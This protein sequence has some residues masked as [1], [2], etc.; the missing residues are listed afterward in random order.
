M[1]LK[2]RAIPTKVGGNENIDRL[3]LPIKLLTSQ[4]SGL[5]KT[6]NG[7]VDTQ[8]NDSLGGHQVMMFPVIQPT[9]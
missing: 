2:N 1:I 4:I 3:T 9:Q 8:M 6:M 5:M 7:N